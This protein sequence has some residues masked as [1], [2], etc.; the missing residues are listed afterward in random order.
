[1]GDHFGDGEFA[2]ARGDRMAGNQA[3]G[4]VDQVDDVVGEAVDEAEFIGGVG[5][6]S[7]QAQAAL[8]DVGGD[9]FGS[10]AEGVVV[11]ADFELE[12]LGEIGAQEFADESGEGVD[13]GVAVADG[14]F[15]RV[16]GRR[17]KRRGK[18]AGFAGTFYARD[19]VPCHDAGDI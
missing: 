14:G 19:S 7:R 13:G 3:V 5:E 15:L 12:E 9:E 18:G 6:G 16:G 2:A 4:F 11:G 17:G 8:A 10:G 1:M